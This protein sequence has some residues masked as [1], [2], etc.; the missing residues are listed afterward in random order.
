MNLNKRLRLASVVMPQ[1]CIDGAGNVPRGLKGES[2]FFACQLGLNLKPEDEQGIVVWGCFH[3]LSTESRRGPANLLH[4]PSR[5]IPWPSS[6]LLSKPDL[7]PSHCLYSPHLSVLSDSGP[8]PILSSLSF[9]EAP[10]RPFPILVF[11]FL[12][13]FKITVVVLSGGTDIQPAW[14]LLYNLVSCSV[15][16]K[17]VKNVNSIHS[18]RL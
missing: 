2:S 12:F 18:P 15:P 14:P 10:L 8:D 5:K 4:G 13:F 16:K 11:Y 9:T 7:L 3:W 6:S 1:K 17:H